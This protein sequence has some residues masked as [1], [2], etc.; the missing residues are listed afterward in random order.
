LTNLDAIAEAVAVG[1]GLAWLPNWLARKQ[2][3][4][5]VQVRVLP[6]ESEY[7]HDVSAIVR[8]RPRATNNQGNVPAQ[9]LH[10]R[11]LLFRRD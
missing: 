2:L 8:P 6:D 10:F 7:L 3:M 1:V 5:G 4:S 11:M 9:S